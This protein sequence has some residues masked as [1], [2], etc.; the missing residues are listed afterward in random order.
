LSKHTHKGKHGRRAPKVHRGRAGHHR[1]GQ[2]GA[3]GPTLSP[4]QRAVLWYAVIAVLAGIP[5]AM[6]KYFE[7]S[8]PGAFDSGSYV[9]SAQKVLRGAEIGVE[10]RP[11][12]QLGT[13]LVN[14]LGVRLCGFSETGPKLVQAVMQ[15]SAL[16]LMLVTLRKAFGLLAA[17]LSV[18]VASI[19][20]SAPTI[21]KF[22]NVK[23]QYMIACMVLGMCC[24]IL[25]QL[26]GGAR[27]DEASG[28]SGKWYLALLAGGFASWGCLFKQTGASVIGAIGLFV[29]TQALFKR[30]T[31]KETGIEVL[32]LF[33]GAAIALAPLYVWIIGWDVQMELPYAFV[34]QT[35]VKLIPSGAGAGAAADYIGASR[36]E[37]PLSEQAPRVLRY[38]LHLILPVALALGA[39]LARLLRWALSR[40]R[41]GR[42]EPVQYEKF[43][44]L[45]GTWWL[46]DMAFVWISPRSYEQYYLPLTASGAM[47]G[48]YLA[49]IFRDGAKAAESR[50]KYITIGAVGLLVMMAMSWQIFFGT[51]TS[52]HSGTVYRDRA[53]NVERR[54]G[55]LQ[56]WREI[57]LRRE[58]M[59]GSWEV[60][61]EY[62]RSHSSEDD[63]IYVWGWWPG[64]YV[65][66]QRLSPAPKAFEGNMHTLPPAELARRVEEILKSFEKTPPKFIV[67]SRKNHFPWDRPPLEL[68]PRTR[69]GFLSTA[70]AVVSAYE[71]AKQLA[72]RIEPEEAER[73]KAMKPFRDYVMANYE[74]VRQFGIHVLFERKQS[75][76]SAG[77][78]G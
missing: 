52:P 38:Y 36:A 45:L 46:L 32:L 47:T 61:A 63:Q 56:K 57:S 76:E 16:V 34:W 42:L 19:Y 31:L 28:R 13:L 35:L 64:I 11:S 27:R 49:A 4:L 71:A 77:R 43:V 3:T 29:V 8:T 18:V 51:T 41:A 6:G 50:G 68:W 58:G 65:L 48:G 75:P 72:E 66:A 5:F 1:P 37:A 30:K 22:G 25:Y 62:I 26:G 9:Y 69:Q 60:L 40:S 24:F 7:L 23:E 73:F 55:Y 2:G 10:E 39:I 67:D 74:V 70:E 12:A 54:R 53:G 17:G 15:V 59:V 78:S 21:A 14:M 44:L 20:L 33:G